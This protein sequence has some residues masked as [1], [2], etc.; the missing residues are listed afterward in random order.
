MTTLTPDSL[1]LIETTQYLRRA[2]EQLSCHLSLRLSFWL[3]TTHP[4]NRNYLELEGNLWPLSLSLLFA[5]VSIL[6]LPSLRGIFSSF[7]PSFFQPC[8][9]THVLCCTRRVVSGDG[10]DWAILWPSRHWGQWECTEAWAA[11]EGWK[12]LQK[13]AGM[14]SGYVEDVTL[15][16]LSRQHC[17]DRITGGTSLIFVFSVLLF[18][19]YYSALKMP[20]IGPFS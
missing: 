8:G 12:A 11:A 17:C 1:R 3:K 19:P 6:L 13:K 18:L 16:R 9:W 14:G 10:G 20:F 4:C 5:S 2:D 7:V 15:W